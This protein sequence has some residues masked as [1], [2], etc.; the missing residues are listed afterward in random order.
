MAELRAEEVH[1]VISI[2]NRY[3][4]FTMSENSLIDSIEGYQVALAE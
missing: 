1:G 3:V 2:N 4:T